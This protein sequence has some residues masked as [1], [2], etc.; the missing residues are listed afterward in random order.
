MEIIVTEENTR[1]PI[2][3]LRVKGNIDSQTHQAFETKA[4]ELIDHGA[5][6]IL[7]DLAD[8]EFVSSAGLR[9]LHNIFNKLRSLH[10]DVDDE[11]L[12]KKMSTG[13][14]RSPYIKIVNPSDQ[15]R[16][17]FVISG[18]DTYIEAYDDPR[19]AIASF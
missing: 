1:V 8:A 14:Y 3:I 6:Y 17:I 18:F 7:V 12:R 4:N 15:I 11:E 9:A 13:G 19:K 16:D 5:R 10:Q 2:T